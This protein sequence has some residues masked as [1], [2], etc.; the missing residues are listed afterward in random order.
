MEAQMETTDERMQMFSPEQIK[1]FERK[2]EIIRAR[3]SGPGEL[4]LPWQLDKRRIEWGI[5]DNAFAV[6]AAYDR[7]L[8]YQIPPR[9]Y[10]KGT[11][12]TDSRI[13]MPDTSKDARTR[14]APRGIIV[15]AGLRALDELRS[16]GMELGD[17]VMF[18]IVQPWKVDYDVLDGKSQG[19]LVM[20]TGHLIGSEDTARRLKE[21]AFSVSTEKVDG[22]EVHIYRDRN[23]NAIIPVAN[24][25]REF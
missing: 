20:H 9:Q 18:N 2:S 5:T 21:G 6:Q 4:G 19:L 14:S 23:G 16:N 25:S 17:I 3:M 8:V 12:G 22:Q 15:S 24:E 13:Q 1:D 10:A 7:I 11:F